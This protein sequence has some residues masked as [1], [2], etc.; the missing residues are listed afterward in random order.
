MK[1]GLF[2]GVKNILGHACTPPVGAD[3]IWTDSKQ[4][5]WYN[6]PDQIPLKSGVKVG[7][8]APGSDS[9]EACP[10][11]TY[12]LIEVADRSESSFPQMS[13]ARKAECEKERQAWLKSRAAKGDAKA[14]LALKTL[15]ATPTL[16]SKAKTPSVAKVAG[17]K[18][19]PLTKSVPKPVSKAKKPTAAKKAKF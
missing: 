6:S 8:A 15:K 17:R 12:T 14:K 5:T 1:K 18:S 4:W 9:G 13:A 7:A 16:A 10:M 2:G 19:V 3:S 11:P